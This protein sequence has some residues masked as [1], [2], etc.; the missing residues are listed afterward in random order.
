[1]HA[2]SDFPSS[3]NTQVDDVPVS[4]PTDDELREAAEDIREAPEDRLF[5]LR[6]ADPAP[7]AAAPEPAAPPRY[8]QLEPD[9]EI[10][11]LSFVK[12]AQRRAL[13]RTPGMRVLLA[14]LAVVLTA[15]LAGQFVYQERDRLAAIDPAWR[16]WLVR[17]CGLLQCTVLPAPRQIESIAIDGSSFNKVRGDTYRLTVTLRNQS[18]LDV[19]WPALEL[20][21]TDAQDQAVV[22]RVLL[23]AE[24]AA[25]GEVLGARAERTASLAVAVNGNSGSRI[26]GYRVLAFYP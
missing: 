16:P 21:L 10:H 13:W 4:Q 5:E 3:L 15:T 7:V 2:A 25:G 23:P 8:Q 22:R 6:R 17:A 26:A 12:Q 1:V 19:A 11:D 20:T 24:T 18:T 9:P 14:L